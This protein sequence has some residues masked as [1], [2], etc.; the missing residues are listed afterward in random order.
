MTIGELSRRSGI[1]ASAI[2]YYED[3]ELL[4]PPERRGGKRVFDETSLTRL[5]VIQFAKN[6]GFT[7][8]E[9][10]QLVRGFE[11]ERWKRL[12]EKKLAEIEATATHLTVMRELLR[13]VVRCGCIDLDE[14]GRLISRR[15][16]G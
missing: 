13:T 2:R 7:L 10:R 16:R 6:A 9:I 1:P 15:T 3:I 14:C 5:T 4:E 11:G 12:A 8:A